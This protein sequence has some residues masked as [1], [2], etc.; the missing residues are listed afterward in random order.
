MLNLP[1]ITLL[2]LMGVELPLR[3]DDTPVCSSNS[4][5]MAIFDKGARQITNYFAA[6]NTI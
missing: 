2:I 1:D 3:S 6:T 5:K 4:R